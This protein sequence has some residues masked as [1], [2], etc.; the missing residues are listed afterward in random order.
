M[1]D[2][3]PVVLIKSDY[4]HNKYIRVEVSGVAL[5]LKI[6]ELGSFALYDECGHMGGNLKFAD[7]NQFVCKVHGWTYDCDGKNMNAGSPGLRKVKVLAEDIKKLVLLLPRKQT[8]QQTNLLKDLIIKVHSHACLT[9]QYSETRVLFDPWI[10]GTAYYGSWHLEPDPVF[11]EADINPTGIIITHPHPDHFHLDTL[12]EINPNIPIYFPNFPSRLIEKGLSQI[13]WKNINPVGWTEKIKIGD[14]IDFEFLRPRSMW[15]DSAVLTTLEDK[16]V[17][18]RWLNLVDAGSVIDEFTLPD[19]DL[20]SSAFDQGASGF[21]LTWNHL[22]KSKKVK[23]LEEQKKQTLSLLPA[24]SNRLKAK[25]FLPFA[26]HWRLGLPEHKDYADSIPHTTF[27]EI[28]ESFARNAENTAVLALKPGFQFNFFDKKTSNV[29][30][31]ESCPANLQK[32]KFSSLPID[33][34]TPNSLIENFERRMSLLQS[35][36]SAF[37][38]EQVKF[39]VQVPE[40]AYKRQFEF[41]LLNSASEA[42]ISISVE[43]P[44]YIFQLFSVGLANWDH[45]AI[46]YW[47]KWDRSSNAYPANFMRLLQSGENTEYGLSGTLLSADESDLLKRTVGDL[48]EKNPRAV[49][50][51]L[52]RAGLPCVMC[53]HANAEKLSDALAIHNIDLDANPWILKELMAINL[54]S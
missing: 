7:S 28:I 32:P 15:E 6:T 8:S 48:I 37:N 42:A 24:R 36:S 25:Y 27:S 16:G 23:I 40:L 45:I 47:G 33:Y 52:N 4:Q 19:L 49:G 1:S 18:F 12:K 29:E 2:F 34:S 41:P 10:F 14:H 11:D 50:M 39:E 35:S 54:V 51:V 31:T 46:G 21:P 38:V 53:T 43:I 3:Q 17:G 13:G 26:G 22:E 30:F 5:W 44:A 9:L 20:L